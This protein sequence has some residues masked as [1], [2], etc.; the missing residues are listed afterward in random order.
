MPT[1]PAT[2]MPAEW[3]TLAD[4][5]DAKLDRSSPPVPTSSE[6]SSSDTDESFTEAAAA[7]VSQPSA[8]RKTLM[9]MIEPRF[10]SAV[11]LSALTASAPFV[12]T[13]TAV[14]VA[15]QRLFG[16]R[17]PTV[18]PNGKTA[19]VSGGKMTKSFLMIKQL[20]AQGCR[21]V[22]VETSKC[23]ASRPPPPHA[24]LAPSCLPLLR[25]TTVPRQVLDGGVA[26]LEVR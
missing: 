25:A 15:F 6:L 16:Q 4:A 5:K 11:V 13:C 12:I 9:Q 23:A 26:L 7:A 10:W 24:A 1:S 20:K 14:V 22:L 2:T 18:K 17:P 19:I 8:E 3:T 21:V